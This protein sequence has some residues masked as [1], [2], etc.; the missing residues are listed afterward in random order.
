MALIPTHVLGIAGT[1]PTFAA[2]AAN[3]TAKVGDH[4]YLEVKNASGSPVNVT[5]AYPGTLPSGDAIPDKVYAVPATTGER[6]IPLLKEYGDPTI[7]GQ[8]AISYSATTSVTR[9]VVKA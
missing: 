3:D 7:G 6:R 9:A 8:V 1:P 5:L 4:M 2:A